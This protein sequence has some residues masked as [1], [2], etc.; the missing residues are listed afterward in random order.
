MIEARTLTDGGQKPS[1]VAALLAGFLGEARKSLDIAIY[2][3]ALSPGVEG[4]VLGAVRDASARGVAVRIA[5]NID[6]PDRVPIPPPARTDPEQLAAAGVPAKGILGVPH[7]MHQKYVVRDGASVWT[8]SANWTDDSWSREEN[9]I[10]TLDSQRIAADFTRDF[11][12]LWTKHRPS[13]RH[14]PRT[15]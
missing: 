6:R 15:R 1:D 14:G 4:P 7:L 9:V 10:V 3:F 13:H 5:Y 12:Q 8:G 11:E 2:D